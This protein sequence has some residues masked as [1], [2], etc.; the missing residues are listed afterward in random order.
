MRKITAKVMGGAKNCEKLGFVDEI[1]NLRRILRMRFASRSRTERALSATTNVHERRLGAEESIEGL[2]ADSGRKLEGHRRRDAYVMQE[3]C[4]IKCTSLPSTLH[5]CKASSTKITI[6]SSVAIMAAPSEDTDDGP[7]ELDAMPKDTLKTAQHLFIALE[8]AAMRLAS[9]QAESTQQSHPLQVSS[10]RGIS[11]RIAP[12][13]LHLAGPGDCETER[14]PVA[15]TI[16]PILGNGWHGCRERWQLGSF[17]TASITHSCT[18]RSASPR[19][20]HF[21]RPWHVLPSEVALVSVVNIIMIRPFHAFSGTEHARR[22]EADV[23]DV[24]RQQL[25]ILL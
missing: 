10:T 7:R 25:A 5:L 4:H 1:D 13:R 23:V 21:T 16:P 19:L 6:S 9:S 2:G 12:S 8:C 15:R 11:V 24:G 22:A 14:L 18:L 20:H 17:C 3:K